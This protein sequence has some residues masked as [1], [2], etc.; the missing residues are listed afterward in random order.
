M[1]GRYLVAALAAALGLTL[2]ACGGGGGG[3]PT[4][5][6]PQTPSWLLSAD[7]ARSR[8]GGDS[9]NR[10]PQQ[11]IAHA[12]RIVGAA[13]VLLMGTMNVNGSVYSV[14]CSEAVCRWQGGTIRIDEFEADGEWQPV[15]SRRG[16]VLAQNRG[17]DA[18]SNGV[19]VDYRGLMDHSAFGIAALESSNPAARAFFNYAFGNAPGTIPG[20]DLGTVTW[21]GVMVA[22]DVR[23]RDTTPA[24]S[25]L[26][27][28]TVQGDATITADLAA[29]GDGLNAGK[30]IPTLD[31]AFTNIRNLGT[32]K[33]VGTM[34]WNDIRLYTELGIFPELRAGDFV[35]YSGGGDYIEGAFFGPEHQ[36]VGG[37]FKRNFYAGAFGA[38]R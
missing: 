9:P 27:S 33:S 35:S 14:S 3:K 22:N 7:G 29:V 4:V 20:A 23:R 37:V 12:N 6:M 32:G 26:G 28:Y 36:E 13:S 30:H 10:T 38:K 25:D 16:V 31:I 11:I 19:G 17:V 2:A 15:M 5:A 24:F 1:P 34:R 21:N 18:E 8:A